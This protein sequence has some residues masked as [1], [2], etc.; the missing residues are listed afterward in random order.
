[1]RRSRRAGEKPSR[2]SSP[3]ALCLRLFAVGACQPAGWPVGLRSVTATRAVEG[4]DVLE[5]DQDVAVQFDVRNAFDAA[6]GGQGSVLVLAPEELDLD[7]FPFVLV[8]VVLHRSERS[9]ANNSPHRPGA[10]PER[11]SG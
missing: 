7:L 1:R 8:R 10:G 3:L 6:V 4:G 2:R 9:G 11:L 5:G